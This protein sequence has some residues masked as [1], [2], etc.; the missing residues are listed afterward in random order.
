[1]PFELLRPDFWDHRSIRW[2]SDSY[3]A[4]KTT[5]DIETHTGYTILVPLLDGQTRPRFISHESVSQLLSTQETADAVDQF[6]RRYKISRADT[7]TLMVQEQGRLEAIRRLSAMA[8]PH[9]ANAQRTLHLT[10][11]SDHFRDSHNW[12][13]FVRSAGAFPQLPP[14]TQLELAMQID[15]NEKVPQVLVS[16]EMLYACGITYP[17]LDRLYSLDIRRSQN[18]TGTAENDF[19]YRPY[20]DWNDVTRGVQLPPP[21]AL[22][23]EGSGWQWPAVINPHRSRSNQSIQAAALGETLIETV[24]RYGITFRAV[25]SE[26]FVRIKAEKHL[27]ANAIM[28][29]DRN[30]GEAGEIAFVRPKKLT[31]GKGIRSTYSTP[32]RL[33]ALTNT[34]SAIL[35]ARMTQAGNEPNPA[36]ATGLVYTLISQVSTK[37]LHYRAPQL[38][39]FGHAQNDADTEAWGN[40]LSTAT[41]YLH[42]QITAKVDTLIEHYRPID[43][44]QSPLPSTLDGYISTYSKAIKEVNNRSQNDVAEQ[45]DETAI[46]NTPFEYSGYTRFEES[47]RESPESTQGDTDEYVD[48]LDAAYGDV[49][50]A[51]PS[52]LIDGSLVE[53]FD[54]ISDGRI[55]TTITAATTSQEDQHSDH[56][57]HGMDM[58]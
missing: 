44:E 58:E 31:E 42:T 13:R 57:G 32:R 24:Q 8:T 17:P 2:K 39:N 4:R 22:V 11:Q 12:E 20:F 38:D 9:D 34:V 45:I 36:V 48:F 18:A 46:F 35:S 51:E 33:F 37:P 27:P 7:V 16:P 50:D 28:F 30:K 15:A 21:P 56:N 29:F 19:S 1:M 23:S 41:Q 40:Q 53:H 25:S 55:V 54:D 47:V 49:S 5:P 3:Q 10:E 26:E 43:N 6:T 14:H 52:H